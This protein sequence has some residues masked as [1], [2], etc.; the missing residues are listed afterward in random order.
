VVITIDGRGTP[1]RSRAFHDV[2]YGLNH[3]TQINDHV[4]AIKQLAARYPGLD[5]QRVGIYGHSFGGYSSTRAILRRPEF[6]KVAVSSAGNQ[7]FQGMYSGGVLG[8]DRL[9]TGPLDYGNGERFRPT[10][11]AVPAVY[12]AF[13]NANLAD[14]LQGKL[15][16]VY[17]DL[18]ENAYPAVTVQLTSALIRANKDFDLLYLPNQDHELFRN[19]PYYTRRMWDY[20][21][22]HLMGAKPPANYRLQPPK[23]LS[24][25]G[26]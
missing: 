18:D 7:N 16:L 9:L 13:D 3:D 6:Y 17:G 4:A 19:D 1:G 15:L 25:S 8:L 2:S 26:F 21:V 24:T 23:Q 5:L 22:E 12:R 20:F 14:R 10:P 11:D